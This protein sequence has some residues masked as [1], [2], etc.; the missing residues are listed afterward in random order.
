MTTDKLNV[1]ELALSVLLSVERGEEYSHTALASLLE[2][3]QYLPK[4]ERS[5]LTRLAEGTLE[6]QIELD[7]IIQLFSNVSITK[8]KPAI[9][10]ILRMGVYQLKYMD[11]VLPYAAC[12][13][14]V[15]LAERKGF[16]NLKGF[17]NGVLR[18]VSRN[19]DALAYPD[20]NEDPFLALSVR[21]SI[22]EWMLRQW[23]RDYGN[24]KMRRIASALTQKGRTSIRVNL[25][26]TTPEDLK[27]SLEKQGIRTE[28]VVLEGIPAFNYAMYISGYDHLCAIPEFC[29]GAFF[30]Q[31]VSSMLA[32][33][34]ASPCPGD[35]VI[36]VCAA[37]G[38]KSLHAADLMRGKGTVEARDVT[39][40]KV[41]LIRE[42]SLR[43]GVTNLRAVRQDA[44]VL[45]E[46]SIEKADLVFAD[47]PCS[48]LG[49]LRRKVDIRCHMTPEKEESLARLQREILSVVRRYVK[50]GGKLF[51]STCTMN[52]MENEENTRWFLEHYPQFSLAM[53]RQIF[54]D[55]GEFDGFYMAEFLFNFNQR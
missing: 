30:V 25:S 4:Q 10:C 26:R 45:E 24:E 3:Y 35:F 42:N 40:Y 16:R 29:E 47:L 11:A 1:R 46:S 52:R 39:E 51:Y 38:G 12:S 6:R 41:G 55:E 19:L 21:H 37:P 43:C 9:R 7:Y 33:H 22:P 32:A 8:M 18:T 23:E 49:T 36:D 20:E 44:L 15:K 28:A 50:P 31:D 54:P 13:E 48:G 2:K 17:V 53:E 5:F 14:A 27:R 34:L